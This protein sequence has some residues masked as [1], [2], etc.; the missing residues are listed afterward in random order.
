MSV[1]IKS[2]KW[3]GKKT[4]NENVWNVDLSEA[5]N[6]TDKNIIY[7]LLISNVH[8]REMH[9]LICRPVVLN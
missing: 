3:K 1:N 9:V 8:E 4:N 2:H 7:I 5:G 6:N